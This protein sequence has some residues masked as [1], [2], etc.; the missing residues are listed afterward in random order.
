MLNRRHI[1]LTPALRA[2]FNHYTKWHQSPAN[3]ALHFLGIPLALI[4]ALGLLAKLP[5]VSVAELPWQPNAGWLALLISG[6]WY[7]WL[8]WRFGVLTFALEV[9]CLLIGSMLSYAV[10]A[11][12]LIVAVIAHWIGHF[13]FERKPPAVFSGPIA[14]LEAPIWLVVNIFGLG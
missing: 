6:V 14:V 1:T 12:L 2:H 5:L 9:A 13:T 3:K 11:T 7:L 10:L 8:D 4:G